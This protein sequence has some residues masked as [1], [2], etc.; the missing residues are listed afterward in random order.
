MSLKTGES[1]ELQNLG[2]SFIAARQEYGLSQAEL[3]KRCGLSQVQISYFELGRRRPTL[4]QL[5]RIARALDSSIQK[6]LTGSNR[7]GTELRDITLELRFLGI[8][9]LW[10]N[11]PVVPGAFRTPEEI[12]PLTVSDNEP[13]P[14]IL[15]A[16]PAILAWN[17]IAPVVLRAYSMTTRPRTARRLAWLADIALAIDRRGGFPGGCR[18]EQLASLISI[19]RTPTNRGNNWDS[20]GRPMAKPPTSPLWRRWRI[21]YD[22]DLDIFVQ[23]ARHLHELRGRSSGI[24]RPRLSPGRK[25]TAAGKHDTGTKDPL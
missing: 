17:K 2:P 22:A 13:E 10:I 8:A 3:A 25:S 1:S 19:V 18:R 12:I 14:R 7:P 24:H 16:M 15:E 6:L 21:T 11:D 4:E 20:L 9:D 23:R 5:L